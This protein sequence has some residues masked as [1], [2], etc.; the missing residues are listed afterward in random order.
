MNPQGALSGSRN[1]L[2]GPSEVQ[3][4]QMWRPGSETEF[5]LVRRASRW[6]QVENE[7]AVWTFRKTANHIPACTSKSVVS[8]L[9]EKI[10]M[11][12]LCSAFVQKSCVLFG[13][14]P[15]QE[16]HGQLTRGQLLSGPEDMVNELREDWGHGEFSLLP[17]ATSWA[18]IKRMEPDLPCRWT[19]KG[20]EIKGT[21]SNTGNSN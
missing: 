16:R 6:T 8:R 12:P 14:P 11:I 19:V 21:K 9:R 17:S 15:V 10:M 4:R 20:G 7:W 1:G 2:T 13:A 5:W 3:P 18:S